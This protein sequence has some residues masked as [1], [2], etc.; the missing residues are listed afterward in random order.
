MEIFG[1]LLNPN[2][3]QRLDEWRV[4][5][6][7]TFEGFRQDPKLPPNGFRTEG[8]LLYITPDWFNGC[9]GGLR[10]IRGVPDS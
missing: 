2:D 8:N 10:N 6:S 1:D 5:H 3:K 7:H 9:F 4:T